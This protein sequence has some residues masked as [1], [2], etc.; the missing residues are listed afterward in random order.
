MNGS[1]VTEGQFRA[2]AALMLWRPGLDYNMVRRRALAESVSSSSS[3]HVVLGTAVVVMGVSVIPTAIGWLCLLGGAL[4]VGINVLRISVDYR[5]MDTDHQHASCFLEQVCGEFFYHTHDFVGLEPR[6]AHSV[7]RIIDSVHSMHTSSAAVWLSAQQL[8][9]IH[10]VAWDA[11][12][13]VAKTRRLRVIVADSPA[14][15]AGIDLTLARSQLAKVDDTVGEIEA[16]ICE[17]VMLMQSW[18]LKLIEIDLRDRLR[19]ELES[20]PY[21]TLHAALR[22]AQSL[23]EAVFSHITAA[24][25][26]TDAG[27]FDWETKHPSRTED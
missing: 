13:T 22:R 16:Y 18:E 14:C 17:A 11:V 1:P 8:H 7:H 23:P 15:A 9:D 27:R 4:A 6:V 3:I 5:Y 24:R 2:G 12:E 25:D 20:G 21:H 19:I 26:L 10:Q